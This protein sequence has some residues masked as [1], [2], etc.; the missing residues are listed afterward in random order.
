MSKE[1]S[2]D[3]TFLLGVLPAFDRFE[4]TLQNLINWTKNNGI[5][6][7]HSLFNKHPVDVYTKYNYSKD[8]NKGVI[9]VGWNQHSK[10]SVS[11]WL[12]VNKSVSNFSFHD[13]KIDFDLPYRKDDPMRS[14]TY[15][16]KE[17]NRQLTNG[18]SIIHNQSILEIS[19]KK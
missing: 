4:I 10:E 1:N 6:Y 16:D 11:N 17:N 3:I 14:W 13:L 2:S 5:V 12:K 8:Y 15:R 18:A 19:I 7:V 9:E